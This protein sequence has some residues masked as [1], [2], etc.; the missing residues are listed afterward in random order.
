MG[1]PLSPLLAELFMDS[2]EQNLFQNFCTKNIV[3]WYRYVDDILCLFKGTKRQLDAF[4]NTL[5]SIEPNIKFTLEIEKDKAINFLD[6][7][8]DHKLNNRL[9]FQIFRKPTYTDT[10]IPANSNHPYCIK[11]AAFHSL[12]NRLLTI[13]LDNK[14]F[15]KE[16]D[17]IITIAENNGYNKDVIYKLLQKKQRK[18]LYER[19]YIKQ[20]IE[21]EKTIYKK[22]KYIKNVTNSLSNELKKLNITPGLYNTGT[23]KNLLVNNKIVRKDPL[24]KSGVYQINCKDCNFKYIGQTRRNFNIRF[25]EH[26]AKY[27]NNNLSSNVAKHLLENN[28]SS[29]KA[30]LKI[31][32][33]EKNGRRL[34][35]LESFEIKKSLNEGINL[36]NEQLDLIDSPLLEMLIP[37]I[38]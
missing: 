16:L 15:N 21:S 24:E 37:E 27:K 28:H 5:N 18:I 35:F 7:T 26:M 31:L 30:D 17:I 8:I 32:H 13:P 25:D 1:S 34:T 23:L 29:E 6:I 3:F 38:S 19:I 36:M 9:N 20:H 14:N 12:I 2:F 22:F 11:M 4:L 10:I 33:Y